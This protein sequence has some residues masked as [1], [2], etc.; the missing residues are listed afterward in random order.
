MAFPRSS[1]SK[2]SVCNAGDLGSIPRLRR[3]FGA[4]NSN[5]LQ[6]SCL[7]NPMDREAW[8]ATVHGVAR[9]GHDLS[10][11]PPPQV[12]ILTSIKTQKCVK[13]QCKEM[14]INLQIYRIG[15]LLFVR[16][17]TEAQETF[18]CLFFFFFLRVKHH[19]K[20]LLSEKSCRLVLRLILSSNMEDSMQ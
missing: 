19:Y 13:N 1:V 7:E 17:K 16:R 6:Y 18:P 5:P 11:K 15:H 9:V 20:R 14:M 2:E 8:H 10:T 12:N 3:F 4:G